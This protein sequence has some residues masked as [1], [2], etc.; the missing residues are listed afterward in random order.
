LRSFGCDLV[1][2]Y[3]VCRPADIDGLMAWADGQKL[4]D[5]GCYWAQSVKTS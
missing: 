4:L 3:L 2:G 1:Q 5:T